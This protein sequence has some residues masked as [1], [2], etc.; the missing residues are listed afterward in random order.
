VVKEHNEGK[1][2]CSLQGQSLSVHID[3]V[4]EEA[5]RPF[6]ASLLD[7]GNIRIGELRFEY[8]ASANARPGREELTEVSDGE[9]LL[10]TVLVGGR[11]VYC[12]KN[13]QLERGKD[14]RDD[15]HTLRAHPRQ[16]DLSGRNTET[17][18]SC[19]NGGI[20]GS[21]GEFGN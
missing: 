20:D 19:R 4:A 17:G 5:R 14:K 21:S 18:C 16:E 7:S 3:T 13:W 12:V 15:N 11:P 2:E 8:A 10:Q 1:D 6:R 9:V